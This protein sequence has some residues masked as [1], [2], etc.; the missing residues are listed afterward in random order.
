MTVSPEALRLLDAIEAIEM[1]SLEWGFTDG[2]LSEHEASRSPTGSSGDGKGDGDL[3]EELI[4]A[5][6]IF[7][8]RTSRRRSA[9]PLALR[10]DDASARRQPATLS[11]TSP[12]RAR[13][14][15]SP[16]SVSTVGPA[17]SRAATACPPT[18]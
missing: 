4:D 7:E 2:S 1:R 12:G 5:K 3:V 16:I 6:L 8:L 15:S 18:S 11:R 14:R 17:A 10:R 13:R 9:H